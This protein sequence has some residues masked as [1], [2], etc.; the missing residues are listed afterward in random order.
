MLL[1]RR[2]GILQDNT[3]PELDAD[4]F[5]VY[6]VYVS[7]AS[8]VST[9]LF[10]VSRGGRDS[11]NICC[12]LWYD[13]GAVVPCAQ[14]VRQVNEGGTRRIHGTTFPKIYTPLNH[15]GVLS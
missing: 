9:H 4:M 6:L 1:V 12:M 5:T 14:H 10:I 3:H 2:G 15:S 8:P 7:T 11:F 13:H